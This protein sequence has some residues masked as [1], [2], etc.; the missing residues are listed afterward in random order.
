[1]SEGTLFIKSWNDL[2]AGAILSAKFGPMFVKYFQ[3]LLATCS[4]LVMPSPFSSVLA[5]MS[6]SSFCFGLLRYSKSSTSA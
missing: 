1:M 6:I 4:A 2:E 5:G 3:N